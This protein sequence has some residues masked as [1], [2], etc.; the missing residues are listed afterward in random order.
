M[1]EAGDSVRIIGIDP[2]TLVAGYAVIEGPAR[3][4]FQPRDFEILD[5]G[6]L[7]SRS[8]LPVTERLGY[9]HES[10]HDLAS[11]W[12]PGF[13]AIERAF[14]GNSAGSALRLGEARG[15]ITSAVRRLRIPV[16]EL[17][18]GTVKKTIAGNGRADKE[19]ISRALAL[20]IGFHQGDL[21]FDVS[22]ALAIALCFGL[23]YSAPRTPTR[24]A[25]PGTGDLATVA[26]HEG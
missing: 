12:Q 1:K 10:F 26:K 5:A 4:R 22:D 7:K 13:C 21:P 9:L 3:L 23:S 2:G 11:R 20:L 15:A 24:Q 14:V 16:H 19:Q 25:G 8:S 18:P 6:A 17:T